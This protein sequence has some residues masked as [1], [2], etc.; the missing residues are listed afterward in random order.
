MGFHLKIASELVVNTR[1]RSY[2]ERTVVADDDAYNQTIDLFFQVLTKGNE[3]EE[4]LTDGC[5][6]PHHYGHHTPHYQIRS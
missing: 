4:S 3:R 1:M 6:S 2:G 5:N